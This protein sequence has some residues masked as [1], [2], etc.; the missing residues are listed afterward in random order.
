MKKVILGALALSFLAIG[1]N[2]CKK[3]VP[4]IQSNL[5][6]E[7]KSS[8][9]YDGV[10]TD[11]T[12]LIFNSVAD[13]SRVVSVDDS[14]QTVD[15]NEVL[16]RDRSFINYANSLNYPKLTSQSGSDSLPELITTILN[17]DAIVQIGDHIYKLD[18]N[19]EK[20]YVMPAEYRDQGFQ[21]LLNLND[22]YKEIR[23]YSFDEDVV[24]L[25]SRGMESEKCGDPWGTY[26][27]QRIP[28]KATEWDFILN[29]SN[30]GLN[31]GLNNTR[32][33][34]VL[35]TRY[36]QLGV[37]N[38]LQARVRIW[39]RTLSAGADNAN[40]T[41][42]QNWIDNWTW[43]IGLGFSSATEFEIRLFWGRKYKRRC[44]SPDGWMTN[45]HYGNGE[46]TGQSWRGMKALA[47]YELVANAY[48]KINGNWYLMNFGD[49]NK[50]ATNGTN[51]QSRIV[52]GY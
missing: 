19:S 22:S 3:Q 27:S 32:Y 11:G 49:P 9:S 1:V 14:E 36:L 38:D 39:K 31:L 52:S 28:D 24:D 2:S 5:N 25:V 33:R 43:S 41:D 29:Y 26:K 34:F 42:F 20:V 6:N 17:K 8:S 21:H 46:A 23:V 30:S 16:A 51:W 18:F 37:Y 40:P 50:T 47:R 10:T 15:Q 13:Y 45:N 7:L 35:R 44:L 4:E 12:I 48:V